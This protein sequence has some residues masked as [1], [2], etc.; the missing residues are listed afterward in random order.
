VL[1]PARG[2]FGLFVPGVEP[3]THIS[4]LWDERRACYSPRVSQKV[5]PADTWG[6]REFW[7]GSFS[8]LFSNQVR[9]W[10]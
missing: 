5:P 8:S 7:K 2:R 4:C 10:D 1:L 9:N 6:Y 3:L